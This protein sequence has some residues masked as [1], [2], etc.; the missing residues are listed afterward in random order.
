MV[1]AATLAIVLLGACGTDDASPQVVVRDAALGGGVPTLLG[2]HADAVYWS[3][4]AS[5]GP[6]LVAGAS[7]RSLPADGKQ[8]GM[9]T[10]PIAQVGDHVIYSTDASIQRASMTSAP[11]KVA[12]VV[13]EALGESADPDP[14]LVWTAG[15]VVSWGNGNAT[16]SAML[17]RIVRCDHLQITDTSIYVA[18]DGASERR[19][20]RVDRRTG[21]V[22][23]LSA[24]STHA[25]SFPGG[26]VTGA[27]YRGRLVGVD[28]GE[29]LWLVEE[30]VAGTTSPDRAILLSVP[31]QGEPAVLLEHVNGASA[32]FTR[33]EAF[34]WQE[35]DAL[36]AAP[37]SGGAASIVHQVT[38]TVGA[39]DS[40]FVYYV[41]GSAI[42]RFALDG[43][44]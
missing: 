19:L 4:S 42:E 8:L 2:A 25:G 16:D 28:D 11:A 44:D 26:E 20:L 31:D 10:G 35:G 29:A 43:A 33:A 1:R 13:A 6:Q 21:A 7:L 24:S 22:S 38:G 14:V 9:A 34:Y 40:G 41:E 5:S 15:A 37:R 27:I 3:V 36:L 18:A 17:S 32:F 23:G 39:I 30:T 12:S